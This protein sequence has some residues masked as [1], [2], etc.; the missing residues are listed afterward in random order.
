MKELFKRT[1]G[2]M[3]YKDDLPFLIDSDY[4]TYIGNAGVLALYRVNISLVV[5]SHSHTKNT[6]IAIDMWDGVIPDY[7]HDE[8][9]RMANDNSKRYGYVK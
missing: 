8:Y 4:I 7:K 2:G 5:E 6:Y 9:F 1:L 3:T